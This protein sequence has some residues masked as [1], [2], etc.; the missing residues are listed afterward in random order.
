MHPD[1]VS[2]HRPRPGIRIDLRHEE[3]CGAGWARVW[4]QRIGDSVTVSA[5]GGEPQRLTVPD[6]YATGLRLHTP[7]VATDDPAALRVC[8]TLASDGTERCFPDEAATTP[9]E[10]P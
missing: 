1:T 10:T 8:V 5:G 7:M 9:R 6:K 3:G 2:T 4:G